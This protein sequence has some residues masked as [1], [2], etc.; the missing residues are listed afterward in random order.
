MT[1]THK[2][3]AEEP[4]VLTWDD[5]Y[6]AQFA[7]NSPF[8]LDFDHQTF[9]AERVVRL[10][11]KKRLVAFGRWQ[12]RDV[13]AKLFFSLKDARQQMEKDYAGVELLKKNKIPTPAILYQGLTQDK[14]IYVLIF[15]RIMDAQN[16]DDIWQSK[17]SFEEVMPILQSV[18][19]EVATQHVLGLMQQD[20]HLKN[21]LYA[22]KSIYTL[23]GAQ[24][25][26][27]DER[28]PKKTSM[29]N[30]ALLLSQLGVGVEIEQE[31]LYEQYAKARGWTVKREDLI[32]LFILIRKWHEERW[33]KYE[34]KILRDSSAYACLRGWTTFGV[35]D[36]AYESAELTAFMRNP[37]SVFH[38]PAA[39]ILKAG[40]S[41]TV[42]KIKFG[43][44]EFVIK[45]YNIKNTWHRLR[46]CLRKTRAASSWRLAQKLRLFDIP[47]AKPVAFIENK[48]LGFRGQSYFVMEYV[49]NE[50]ADQYFV[51]HRDNV[52]TSA[53]MVKR[54]TLLLKNIATLEITH[55][56]LKATNILIGQDNRPLLIDLDGATE[57]ATLSG[58]RKAW[59]KEIERFLENFQYQRNLREQFETEFK[60]WM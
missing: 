19:V 57:Y 28:L 49:P 23:D 4:A 22:D 58:L 38:S 34:K 52:E 14:R 10:L 45:R 36:R 43:R 25:E 20:L 17:K 41:S 16:L 26:S 44:R 27:V 48:V 18:V 60:N 2:S 5:L 29:D 54:I 11:P 24:I 30:L 59:H 21:F 8:Q 53:E 3:T 50:T 15:E 9:M 40:R 7:F 31:N 33:R 39:K 6:N 55:G 35:Y 47:T 56:D 1:S 42:I 46:R 12:N 51:R 13:V 32:E 37:D